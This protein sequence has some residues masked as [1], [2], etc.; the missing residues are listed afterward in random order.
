VDPDGCATE[1]SGVV[2]QGADWKKAD[3]AVFY[4]TKLNS[5]QQNY[6]AHEIELVAGITAAC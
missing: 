4:S 2:N 6:L 5:A 3:V 1:I